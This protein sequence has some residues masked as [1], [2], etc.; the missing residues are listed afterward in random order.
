VLVAP[1]AV[2]HDPNLISGQISISQMYQDFRLKNA[3]I[4]GSNLAFFHHSI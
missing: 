1:E 3:A 2:R 4:P